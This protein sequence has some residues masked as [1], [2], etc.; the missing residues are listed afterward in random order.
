MGNSKLI[1]LKPHLDP[2]KNI[3]F[4]G[5]I[6]EEMIN[7]FNAFDILWFSPENSEKLEEWIAFTNV[8]VIKVSDEKRLLELSSN[9]GPQH[10]IIIMEGSLLKKL[11]QKLKELNYFLIL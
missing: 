7:K 8:V 2:K 10:L 11:F 4:G 6:E 9:I 1:Q 3:S 5:E